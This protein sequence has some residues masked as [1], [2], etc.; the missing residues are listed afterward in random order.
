MKKG[1]LL[2]GVHIHGNDLAVD[3]AVERAASVF[4]DCA[5][6]SLPFLYETIV[7]AKVASRLFISKLF[8]EP[9]LMHM[10]IISGLAGVSRT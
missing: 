10:F 9:G 8:V 5:Y 4:A 6:A 3:K 7:V 1:L 2:N